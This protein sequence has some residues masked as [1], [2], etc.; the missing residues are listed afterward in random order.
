MNYSFC[1]NKVA[2]WS[3]WRFFRALGPLERPLSPSFSRRIAP[4]AKR[5]TVSSPATRDETY[6][7]GSHE[8][9]P[10]L[11][12]DLRRVNPVGVGRPG[13]LCYPQVQTCGYSR[14]APAGA[15][16][17]PIN[18]PFQYPFLRSRIAAF[19]YACSE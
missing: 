2:S 14:S 16:H 6:G 12:P 17:G 8:I 5:Q 4:A 13:G 10:A 18:P 19:G 9:V 3:A 1:L 15:C 11:G 7:K